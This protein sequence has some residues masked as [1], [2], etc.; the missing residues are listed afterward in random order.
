MKQLIIR[1]LENLIILYVEDEDTVREEISSILKH[2]CPNVILAKNGLDG[3]EKYKK[4]KPN[5]IISDIL[6]P[7]LDGIGMVKKIRE[8]DEQTPILFISSHSD[9][10]T[11][12]QAVKL[13]LQ[14]YLI[15]PVKEEDIFKALRSS[16][17]KIECNFCKLPNGF[18]YDIQNKILK[19]EKKQIKL[20]K[21]ESRFLE[22]L[23][24]HKKRIVT[25][26]ELQE[27]VWDGEVMTDN[28]LRS[29][30]FSLRS[31][32]KKDMIKNLSGFGY[33]LVI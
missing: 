28:A 13:N 33:K 1:R 21:K 3:L 20:N 18:T 10:K 9:K 11:L 22:L 4:Y 30:V 19:K 17:N 6:M 29:L 27:C 7:E 2:Y 5:I 31:K 23:M 15:K 25:Y 26:E 8:K 14:D 12:L 32:L 24:S 16:L